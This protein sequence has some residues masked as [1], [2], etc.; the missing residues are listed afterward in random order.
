M[1]R[2]PVAIVGIGAVTVGGAGAKAAWEAVCAGQGLAAPI[3]SFDPS[4]FPVRFGCEVDDDHIADGLSDKE[5]RRIDRHTRLGLVAAL[6]SVAAA[7]ALHP[8][9]ASADRCAVVV[10]TAHAGAS[11][12]E[13]CWMGFAYSATKRMNPL[14]VPMS[15]QNALA[16]HLSMYLGWTG[17]SA[18]I[19]SACASGSEAVGEGVRLIRE[20]LADVVLAGGAEATITPST[21]A[22]FAALRAL[23]TRNDDPARASRPFD[24]QRDGFVLGEGAGFCVLE[25]V[26]R[27][28]RRGAAPVALAGGYGRTSDA[29]HIVMPAPDGSGAARC[30][31]LALQDAGVEPS[32][33]VQINAH[34]TSTPL[35]D[36]AEATAIR[37]VF[38]D[39]GPPVTSAKGALGHLV[40]AAGAVEIVLCCESLLHGSVPPTANH[41]RLGDGLGIDVVSG[42]PRPMA[43]GPILT[44]SFG[45]GG[46]NASLVLLPA[47][48]QGATA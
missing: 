44:N 18:T 29:H 45:F 25:S 6:E 24:A 37:H 32:D 14:G 16:A 5:R 39:N 19:S 33:V 41:D 21:V 12:R 23:S 31:H 28:R 36:E 42:S 7:E 22:G 46:H 26:A 48:A 10:G 43:H 47:S 34:G 9:G 17:P 15:M 4:D 1:T 8:L 40:G 30:M 11:A 2:A 13:A 3:T 38:G 35:N 20:G 27:A